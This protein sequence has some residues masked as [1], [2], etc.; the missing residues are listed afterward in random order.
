MAQV[1]RRLSRGVRPLDDP[2]LLV[3]LLDQD[4]ERQIEG[5]AL[6]KLER[7]LKSSLAPA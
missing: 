7:A 6:G 4:L 1:E 3:A 5:Q 2:A